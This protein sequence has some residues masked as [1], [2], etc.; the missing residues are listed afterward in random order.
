M[1]YDYLVIGA[2]ISGAAAAHELAASGTVALIEAEAMPGYHSTGRSAALFTPNYGSATVRLINKTS[3]AF[4][5]EPPA[6][7]CEG[8]LLTRRG[9][10]TVAAPGEEE[11]AGADPR[12]VERRLRNRE[13]GRGAHPR[14]GAAAPPRTRRGLGL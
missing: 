12:P 4:F 14:A 9:M 7:F 13:A 10:L 3:Q 5:L 2:G 1:N 6:D 11:P 8:P